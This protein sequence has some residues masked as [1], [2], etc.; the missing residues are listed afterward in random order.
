MV[1]DSNYRFH[2]PVRYFTANDPYYW[3]IDNI[4]LKQLMENDLWL[5]DQL[6]AG[7]K[8]TI[9][10]IDRTA[11]SELKPYAL[12][13]DNQ[14]K[15]K[16]GRYTAR[17]N[18]PMVDFR[19]QEIVRIRAGTWF[20]ND[21]DLDSREEIGG[22]AQGHAW[23]LATWAASSIEDNVNKL[24]SVISDDAL[25]LNGLY[26]RAFAYD[27][28]NSYFPPDI[29][30]STNTGYSQGRGATGGWND[31]TVSQMNIPLVDAL[32]MQKNPQLL[33][34]S[35]QLP[36]GYI[37]MQT[38]YGVR[39]NLIASKTIEHHF[40]KFWRGVVRTAVVDV[41]EELSIE[42]PPFN[43]N[44]FNYV[45]EN[46]VAQQRPEAEVRID[47]LFIYSKPVDAPHVKIRSGSNP[48]T[49]RTINQ[50]QL[51]LVKGAGVLLRK[52]VG[53]YGTDLGG[54]ASDSGSK[55]LAS[56]ADSLNT[57]G[58]FQREQVYGSFP[59][60]DD[61]MNLTPLLSEQLESDS[62]LLVGQSILPIAYV[63]VRNPGTITVDHVVELDDIIDI[64]P[65]FRTTELSYN[66]RAG[67]AA[68]QPPL[69]FSNPVVT[70]EQLRESDLRIK[71][72]IDVKI[73]EIDFTFPE[74]SSTPRIIHTGYI[75]G[76]SRFGPESIFK[77]HESDPADSDLKQILVDEYGYP[78]E[79]I[80]LASLESVGWALAPWSSNQNGR[81]SYGTDYLEYVFSTTNPRYTSTNN[82]GRWDDQLQG[83]STCRVRKTVDLT[84]TVFNNNPFFTTGSNFYINATLYNCIFLNGTQN[85]MPVTPILISIDKQANTATFEVHWTPYVK[86][87]QNNYTDLRDMADRAS[88][89]TKEYKYAGTF[90]NHSRLSSF[91][92]SI[93]AGKCV[94]PSIKYEVV[95]IPAGYQIPAQIN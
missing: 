34:S 78:S 18:D 23:K 48:T 16:P 49:T 80:Q 46:G 6:E 44:D 13:V 22:L 62:H 27:T 76:G 43:I 8:I 28:W 58:G 21:Q 24:I 37:Q 11:F 75:L 55:I 50:P 90:V 67:I 52:D 3:E 89:R 17:I 19:L 94:L 93:I 25:F 68:A 14:V 7:L 92:D 12:G 51:G 30:D 63:V 72:Y 81:G 5:K 45:D 29:V 64:R 1:Y 61:L 85:P 70:R 79:L 31:T 15:V 56:V 60:P 84:D 91:G 33:G 9:D 47:L 95:A 32:F 40:I 65:F 53:G 59:A 73:N 10:E 36:D 74:V 57:S 86:Y 54:I 69:S 26:E 77:Q 42:I 38:N 2:D 87:T 66:E 71:E 4:P 35:F 83:T 41:A 88:H 20:R 39:G 82:A